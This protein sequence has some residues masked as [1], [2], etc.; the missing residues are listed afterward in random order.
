MRNWIYRLTPWIALAGAALFIVC[1]LSINGRRENMLVDNGE[2]TAAVNAALEQ[3]LT[4]HPSGAQDPALTD[5]LRR[6]QSTPYVATVFLFDLQGNVL[7]SEGATAMHLKAQK[8]VG[9]EFAP[10]LKALP[11][12]TLDEEQIALLNAVAAMRAEGEHNDIYLHRVAPVKDRNGNTIA[13][14]GVAYEI[15]PALGGTDA[16]WMLGILL[17]LLGFGLYWLAL[18][19]WTYL[20]A[21]RCG[22]PAR[23]WGLFVLLGNLVALLAYLIVRSSPKRQ[24]A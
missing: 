14:L 1:L 3:T 23:I 22:E 11:E 20:D 5:A 13:V 2:T 17:M 19:L 15:S 21:E 12:N 9:K 24:S 7:Y 4:F 6:F 16:G 8:R 10:L 18:P